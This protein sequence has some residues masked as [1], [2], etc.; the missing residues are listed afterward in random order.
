MLV[1]TY[2]RACAHARG[3]TD[4]Y[5]G[6]R[7]AAPGTGANQA[8]ANLPFL[9]ILAYARKDRQTERERE[10]E[11][12]GGRWKARRASRFAWPSAK[13]SFAFCHGDVPFD[14]GSPCL[15]HTRACACTHTRAACGQPSAV[16]LGR[17]ASELTQ[18]ARIGYC[19]IQSSAVPVSLIRARLSRRGRCRVELYLDEY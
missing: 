12:E 17:F 13:S 15:T 7:S 2:T 9:S 18:W 5:V 1:R 6:G 10:G 3:L 4:N 19:C 11:R 8:D 14:G 16:T